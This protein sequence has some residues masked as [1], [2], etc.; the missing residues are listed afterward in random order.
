MLGK[1][2]YI[3]AVCPT[4]LYICKMHIIPMA[5]Y[6]KRVVTSLL[7]HWSYISFALS[8]QFK[9]RCCHCRAACPSQHPLTSASTPVT[10]PA[11]PRGR[12]QHQSKQTETILVKLSYHAA[13]YFTQWD[14]LDGSVQERRNSSALALELHLSCTK[15]LICDLLQG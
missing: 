2:S 4:Y 3:F 12:G 6:C 5:L 1:A 11:S 8:Q 15:P 9:V 7:K 14:Y 13:Q 10:Q